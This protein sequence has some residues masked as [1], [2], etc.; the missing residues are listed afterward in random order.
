[1]RRAAILFLALTLAACA[2]LRDAGRARS[3]ADGMIAAAGARGV[4]Q[5]VT[6]GD[7]PATLHPAS[8]LICWDIIGADPPARL[9]LAPGG[10]VVCDHPRA[11]SADRFSVRPA[12]PGDTASTV[13]AARIAAEIAARPDLHIRP[14]PGEPDDERLPSPVDPKRPW[15]YPGRTPDPEAWQASADGKTLNF[16]TARVARGRVYE[17]RSEMPLSS[18]REFGAGLISRVDDML[19]PPTQPYED[20][21]PLPE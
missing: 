7:T 12:A 2:S 18:Y 5:N 8:G 1:M 20:R 14:P 15:L 3:Q 4:M 13:L 11:Y 9:T 17:A 16:H 21:R 10:A 6:R 19:Y